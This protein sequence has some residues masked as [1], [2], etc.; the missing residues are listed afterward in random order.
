MSH[1][2][3]SLST[4]FITGVSDGLCFCSGDGYPNFC[5]SSLEVVFF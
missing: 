2:N 5:L 3:E 4:K 1:E